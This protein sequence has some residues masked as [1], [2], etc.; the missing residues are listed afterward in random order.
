VRTSLPGT[1]SNQLIDRTNFRAEL[2]RGIVGDLAFVSWQASPA[3]SSGGGSDELNLVLPSSRALIEIG[4]RQFESN[5][6]S[7]F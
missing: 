1:A 2:R 4:G 3:Y 5:R 6:D 7:L